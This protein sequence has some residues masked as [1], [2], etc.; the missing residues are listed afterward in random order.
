[1]TLSRHISRIIKSKKGFTLIELLVVIGILGILAA[2]LLAA[3]DP[4]EQ[5]RKAQD[6]T[7]QKIAVEYHG[8]LTRYYATNLAMP[9]GATPPTAGLLSA[10]PQTTYTTALT[11]R[12]ELKTTFSQAA[13]NYL[14]EIY[15]TGT[16]TGDV[17]VC[18]DPR[19]KSMTLQAGTLYT[20]SGAANAACPAT[21]PTDT[22][23]H[24]C[25][26]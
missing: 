11:D 25:A 20:N 12:G 21:S 7:R 1:M 5:L 19:S 2:G 14:G 9:W 3:I 15:L 17:I 6:Q 24:W 26:R 13:G 4:L 23:C 16:S 22:S 8:A 10:A 18:F